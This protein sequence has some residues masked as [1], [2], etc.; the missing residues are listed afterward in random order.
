MNQL[1]RRNFLAAGTV[2]GLSLTSTSTE[3]A[4]VGVRGIDDGVRSGITNPSIADRRD[5]SSKRMKHAGAGTA[6][7][8]RPERRDPA[9]RARTRQ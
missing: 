3:A 1:T 9:S 6:G 2:T 4:V 8:A 7:H 5:D